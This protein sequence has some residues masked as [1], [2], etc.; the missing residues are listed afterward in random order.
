MPA[1]RFDP[2]GIRFEPSETALDE[3]RMREAL[4]Q[5]RPTTHHC[6]FRPFHPTGSRIALVDP[7]SVTGV[8]LSA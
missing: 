6:R 4:V 8:I 3:E 1:F 2:S 7:H 5:R